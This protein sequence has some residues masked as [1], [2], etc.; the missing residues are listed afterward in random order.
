MSNLVNPIDPVTAERIGSKAVHQVYWKR[1]LDALDK[2]INVIVFN[3]LID[4]TISAH[5]ARAALQGKRWGIVLI[6]F[7]NWF[8]PNHGAGAIN[9]DAAQA[10]AIV[11]IEKQQNIV[12]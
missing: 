4:E 7:L 5:S 8:D 3:G 10:Q 11:D 2:F 12:K 1:A 9:D 6:T